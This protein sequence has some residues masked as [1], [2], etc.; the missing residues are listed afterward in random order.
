MIE[1]NFG[2]TSPLGFHLPHLGA[3]LH[4]FCENL[5]KFGEGHSIMALRLCIGC[6]RLV[7]GRKAGNSNMQKFFCNTMYSYEPRADK[8]AEKSPFCA[9]P[10]KLIILPFLCHWQT[11]GTNPTSAFIHCYGSLTHFAHTARE[12][13]LC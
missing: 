3:I 12:E 8:R 4:T 5:A 1:V 9:L 6:P 10:L 7:G 2:L 13:P 11:T